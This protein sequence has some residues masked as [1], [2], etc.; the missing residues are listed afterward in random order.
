MKGNKLTDLEILAVIR[1]VVAEET[2]AS[3]SFI[4]TVDMSADDVP[5]WDSLAHARIVLGLEIAIG[6]PID[7]DDT[8]TATN[9]KELVSVIQ[10]A[11]DK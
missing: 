5:G 9:I 8:Y 3:D 11:L 4:L 7:I 10:M 6:S 2:N 1:D